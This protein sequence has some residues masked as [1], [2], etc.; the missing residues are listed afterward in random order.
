MN[1]IVIDTCAL[2]CAFGNRSCQRSCCQL[3]PQYMHTIVEKIN[4]GAYILI[5][6]IHVMM[7]YENTFSGDQYF[8]QVW[9]DWS[10]RGRIQLINTSDE[11]NQIFMALKKT[12]FKRKDYKFIRL[13]MYSQRRRLISEDPDFWDPIFKRYSHL[14]QE[15]KKCSNKGRVIDYLRKNHKIY[16]LNLKNAC[17]HL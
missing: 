14:A 1:K 13:V 4:N 10:L 11:N 16:V 2:S 17:G 6:D 8:K 7:E 3:K 9:P 5:Y 12:G 15:Q